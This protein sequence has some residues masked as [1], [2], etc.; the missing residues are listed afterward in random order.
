MNQLC[1]L[2]LPRCGRMLN[3]NGCLVLPPCGRNVNLSRNI[4]LSAVRMKTF[5]PDYLDAAGAKIP[6]YPPINIQVCPP[7]IW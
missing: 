2:V 3:Y 6:T 4:S 1:K 5:E 7:K